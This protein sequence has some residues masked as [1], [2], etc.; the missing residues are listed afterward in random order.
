MIGVIDIIGTKVMHKKVPGTFRVIKMRTV[1]GEPRVLAVPVDAPDE[2]PRPFR[3][4][5]CILV[6]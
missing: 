4:V 1:E 6:K 2:E 5:D 3:L